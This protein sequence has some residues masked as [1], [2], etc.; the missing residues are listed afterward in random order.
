MSNIVNTIKASNLNLINK[1]AS[2]QR[3]S[4][5][6]KITLPLEPTTIIV[7]KHKE[8]EIKKNIIINKEEITIKNVDTDLLNFIDVDKL[9][10]EKSSQYVNTYDLKSLKKYAKAINI[11]FNNLNKK[12]LI[13][14]INDKINNGCSH[15]F[16]RFSR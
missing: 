12:V 3:K 1:N 16:Q 8:V 7:N 10:V 15:V 6:L 11:S 14:H 2:F 5:P 13:E 4:I 9:K